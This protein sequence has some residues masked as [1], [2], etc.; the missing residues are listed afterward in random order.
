LTIVVNSF[1]VIGKHALAVG[2]ARVGQ[3]D[4]IIKVGTLQELQTFD[5]GKPLHSLVLVSK[6]HPVERDLLKCFALD[7]G[8]YDEHIESLVI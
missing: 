1:E 5:F 8:S 3:A 7:P 6:I 2:F 4:Q